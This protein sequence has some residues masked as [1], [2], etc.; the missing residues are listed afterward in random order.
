MKMTWTMLL[1]AY[2]AALP[3]H[4][5]E[6]GPHKK[7]AGVYRV[8]SGGLGDPAAPTPRDKKV[9]FAISGTAAKEIFEAIGPDKKDICT[10]G[11]S[12]RVRHSDEEKISCMRSAKGEYS[13]NFGF[14]LV[15]GKSIGGIVC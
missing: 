15:S 4:A 13:C 9:M 1:F 5:D 3:G 2:V 8:Y 6:L 14:D 12:F 10:E 7:L 11:S